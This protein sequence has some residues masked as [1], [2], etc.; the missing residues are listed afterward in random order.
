MIAG[1]WQPEGQRLANDLYLIAHD[2]RSGRS[3]LPA[4]VLALGLAGA[5]LAELAA[6]EHLIVE[7]S[8]ILTGAAE[9]APRDVLAHE[10]LDQARSE[11]LTVHDWLV[12]FSRD[13]P[14]RV[15]A[16]LGRAG[17]L[18]H[19][20]S[21]VPLRPGRWVPVDPNAAVM[22][23]VNLVTRL[24]RGQP[25]D[26]HYTALGGL[27]EAVG[28][29]AHE[30]VFWE[31]HDVPDRLAVLRRA[32]AGLPASLRELIAHVERAVAGAYVTHRA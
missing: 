7:D 24:V 3:R 30:H 16:R 13:A 17:V 27:V 28:L 4:R 10:V 11:T 29:G 12:F 15:A 1:R 5:L 20:A 26:L 22:P 2:D 18:A 23:Q 25:L 9:Q 32:V 19:R 14:A 21:P 6:G 8:V 31:I